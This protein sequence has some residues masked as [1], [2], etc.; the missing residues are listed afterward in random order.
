MTSE[1]IEFKLVDL[2]TT[3]KQLEDLMLAEYPGLM[4]PNEQHFVSGRYD[5]ET[6]AT[7]YTFIDLQ[8]NELLNY[9]PKIDENIKDGW[10]FVRTSKSGDCLRTKSLDGKIR[11]YT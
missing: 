4:F 9:L 2:H 10:Y 1:E 8:E 5:F 11:D 6:D 3:S 7:L